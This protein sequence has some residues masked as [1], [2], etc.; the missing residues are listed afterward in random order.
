MKIMP[1]FEV[2]LKNRFTC[3]SYHLHLMLQDGETAI[4]MEATRFMEA[5]KSFVQSL[6]TQ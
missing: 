4:N 2:I 3:C 1:V 6:T 5:T